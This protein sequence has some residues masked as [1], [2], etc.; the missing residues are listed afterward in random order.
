[1]TYALRDFGCYTVAG[2]VHEVTSGAPIEVNFTR[3]ASYSHD[4]KGHFAVEHG[5]VQY[6]VPERRRDAPPVVLVHGGGMS[7]STYET[8]LDGRPG[9]LNRLLQAGFEVH[10]LDNVE[11][12]RAGFVPGLWDGDPILRSL[13]EAWSLFR[14]GMP[15]NFAARKPFRKTQFPVDRLEELAR[16]FCPRWLTTTPKQIAALIA[17]LE[18]TGPATVIF[19][20]QGGEIAFE[21][22]C[23]RP[24]LFTGLVGV[25]PS[26]MP[27]DLAPILHLPLVLLY[28]DN[29]DMDSR[30]SGRRDRWNAL[31][32]QFDARGGHARKILTADEVAPGASHL[33]MMDSR[34]DDNLQLILDALPEECV[35]PH[36]EATGWH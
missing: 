33:P 16:R 31:V 3:D 27:R 13:E 12:G 10:V 24:E 32:E 15:E 26:A 20:S 14:I 9:W 1:M 2:R 11:R 29:L 7:G 5:Y 35:G 21:T 23:Q 4:P 19:H 28:G 22:A 25:E 34:S 8:T 30:W 17:L 6:F 36:V 18:R